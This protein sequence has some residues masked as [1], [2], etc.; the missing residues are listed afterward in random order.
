MTTKK[1]TN[2]LASVALFGELYDSRKDI[3][4]VLAEFLK[5]AI[6]SEAKWSFNVTDAT[7]LLENFYDFK[8]PSAVVKQTLKSRL[9]RDKIVAFKDGVYAVDL[10]KAQVDLSISNDFESL[11]EGQQRV[12]DELCEYVEQNV[13]KRLS[14]GERDEVQGDFHSFLL[15]RGLT[16]RYTQY[17]GSFVITRQ[18]NRDFIE[19]LNS[20]KEGLILYA[21]IRY[22]GDL[23]DLGTWN[24]EFTIF[25]DTEILFNAV[26]Y[27]GILYQQIFDD[28]FGLVKEI[29]GFSVRKS[30]KRLIELKY[31]EEIEEEI[32]RF[33]WVA[34]LILERKARLDPSKP[35]MISIL[36][37]C[38]VPSDVVERK[39]KF[40]GELTTM[41][42][43]REEKVD[44]Y[45]N[46]A[47]IVEGAELLDVLRNESIA[48]NR[49]LDE[50]ECSHF[51]RLFT[52]I[53]VLRKGINN[54]G[55]DRSRF[56]LMT[57]NNLALYL[58][59]HPKVKMDERDTPYASSVDFITDKIWFRLK[60]GF[61]NKENLPKSF[62]FVTKAQMVLSSQV[63]TSIS[64]RFQELSRRVE[65]GEFTQEQALS[66]YSDF[67]NMILKP[68][69]Y[70]PEVISDT[71]AF[72]NDE[73]LERHLQEKSLLLKQIEEGNVAKRQLAK[74]R[75]R[76]EREK[77]K[78]LKIRTRAAFYLQV[79]FVLGLVVLMG[80]FLWIF[81]WNIKTERDTPIGVYSFLFAIA[82]QVFGLVKYTKSI[83]RNLRRRAIEFYKSR[84][85]SIE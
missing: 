33:F 2:L 16:G 19:G 41:G 40:F 15:E 68:E 29:N 63:N 11:R 45:K 69:E 76:N 12:F 20:I 25:L 17:I 62:D 59:F 75:S 57:G 8:I 22:T 14:P 28:F 21:G 67:R 39:A 36:N 83:C 9:Q 44:Y 46:H 48:H 74:I 52:K 38:K 37:G 43:H 84:V 51:L 71:L 70:T 73:N 53:N 35:A 10:A 34:G 81:L 79:V 26:G 1:D 47:Y 13:G 50:E 65:S 27:N 85:S 18:N 56:M 80:Y 82:L 7:A 49:L 42:I 30:G 66:A 5:A 23:N 3:Y 58:A 72:L 54:I 61:S 4:D 55:F 78:P 31:F 64:R 60:K 77:R 6:I 32:N 24:N